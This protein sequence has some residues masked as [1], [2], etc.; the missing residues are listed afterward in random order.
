MEEA[1]EPTQG[2][3]LLSLLAVGTE[4]VLTGQILGPVQPE[5]LCARNA[6][7]SVPLPLAN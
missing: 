7:I 5:C 1:S 4:I 3:L 6:A 2:V